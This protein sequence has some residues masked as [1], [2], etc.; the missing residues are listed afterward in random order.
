MTTYTA[1][2]KITIE[3]RDSRGDY[4][5]LVALTLVKDATVNPA[6]WITVTGWRKVGRFE[7]TQTFTEP[8]DLVRALA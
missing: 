1:G 8:A 2:T 7:E 3:Q 4:R 5:G 6:G